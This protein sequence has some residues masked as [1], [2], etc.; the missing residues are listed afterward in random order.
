MT[1]D[2][3]TIEIPEELR[4][5]LREERTAHESNYAQT[6]ERL[7][8]ESN[9]QVWTEQELRDIVQQELRDAQRRR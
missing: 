9:G 1:G 4:D 8:G 6:I 7:L 2:T 3:T 5:K